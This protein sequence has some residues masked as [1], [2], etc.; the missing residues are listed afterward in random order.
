MHG[1]RPP[2]GHACRYGSRLNGTAT[3]TIVPTRL[4]PLQLGA[5][6]VIFAR[7]RVEGDQ[8]LAGAST[9]RLVEIVFGAPMS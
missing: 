1:I 8:L 9:R 4:Q 2:S 6:I 7:A 3:F 5:R